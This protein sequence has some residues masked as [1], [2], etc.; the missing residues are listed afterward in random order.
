MTFIFK[1]GFAP[2]TTVFCFL[3]FF[4]MVEAMVWA[5]AQMCEPI[6]SLSLITIMWNVKSTPMSI[7]MLSSDAIQGRCFSARFLLAAVWLSLLLFHWNVAL[8]VLVRKVHPPHDPY[9][10]FLQS[11]YILFIHLSSIYQTFER[12]RWLSRKSYLHSS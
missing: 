3:S 9:G 12:T 5:W 10:S 2:E 7:F 11:C 4:W 8:I 6:H 1:I